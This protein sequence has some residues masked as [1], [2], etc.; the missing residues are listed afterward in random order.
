MDS[1]RTGGSDSES[2]GNGRRNKKTK[3]SYLEEELAKYEKGR[4]LKSKKDGRGRKAKDEGDV[5]AK[6][7]AFKSKLKGSFLDADEPQADSGTVDEGAITNPDGENAEVA[8]EIDNDTGFLSHKL[9]FPKD[10]DEEVAKA[11]RDY[12]VIDPRQR[13]ARA[14]EEERE[15]KKQMRPRD[16]GRGFRR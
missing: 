2:D 13:S 3:H 5:L 11:E 6:M 14:K 9:L 8:M 16:G 1:R 12:E 4:G 10:N 7:D 15:R